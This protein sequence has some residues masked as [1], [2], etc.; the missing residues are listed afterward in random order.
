MPLVIP[1][2]ELQPGMKLQAP[3]VANNR[4][5]LQA[6]RALTQT[7]IDAVRARFPQRSVRVEDPILD[8][9]IEFEDDARDRNIA[10]AV[11]TKVATSMSQVQERFARQT[12][13]ANTDFSAIETA[14]NELL[15][16]LRE[17]KST[18]AIVNHCLDSENPFGTHT[19][20]VFYISMM[21]GSSVLS[22]IASERQRQTNAQQVTYRT[23]S[24]L[25]PLG[26]AAMVMDLGMGKLA[27]LLQDRRILTDEDNQAIRNHPILAANALP[28]SFSPVARIAVKT[29]HENV[30]GT[31]YPAGLPGDR[32]HIFARILR[33]ADA[34]VAMTSDQLF[35]EAKSSARALW[36]MAIGP[37][38][39]FYDPH[40][41][42]AFTQ[43]LQPFPIGAKLRLRDGRYAPVVRYN[44][45][46]PFRPI[47]IV[48]FDPQGE[49]LPREQLDK[50]INLAQRRDVRVASWR[51][52]DLSFIYST[53]AEQAPVRQKF[54]TP[55][56]AVC[57]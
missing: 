44:R 24:D 33:I 37:Y 48:A 28:E 53:V 18:A 6:G 15:E 22:Y 14:V 50:P 25:T 45:G 5:L 4:V 26:L 41:L 34:F 19:G 2:N 13:L 51:G 30:A 21:L 27:P 43:L 9:V 29:H 11:Q 55:I 7:E 40:L 52:E 54:R 56:E 57:P 49:P 32:V 31:G 16:F 8:S 38:K 17:N 39:R 1:T 35:G 47:V 3:L 12:Q 10:T 36:E 42:H 20:N 46:D 23:A